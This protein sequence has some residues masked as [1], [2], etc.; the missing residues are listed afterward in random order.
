MLA[1]RL[2]DE[3]KRKDYLVFGDEDINVG[4]NWAEPITNVI[5]EAA[6][7][8][9]VIALLTEAALTVQFVESEICYALKEGGNIFPVIVGDIEL[10]REMSFMLEEYQCYRLPKDPT[11][12][13]LCELV[14]EIGYDIIKK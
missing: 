3:L 1:K 7:E 9:V 13:E 5:S 14:D 12:A 11:D 2:M 10:P 8:G 4:M 6:K